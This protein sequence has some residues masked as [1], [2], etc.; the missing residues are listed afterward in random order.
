MEYGRK[1]LHFDLDVEALKR[2]YP[3]DH[4]NAWKS[5]WSKVKAFME[6]HGFEHSQY[7]GYESRGEMSYDKAYAVLFELS[8][9]Y[10]W[11]SKCAQAATV[12]EIG[13]R[14]D[15]LE[16]LRAQEKQ[17][18]QK[19]HRPQKE[20]ATQQSPSFADRAEK[21]RRASAAINDGRDGEGDRNIDR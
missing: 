14:H 15:V 9:A 12:T 7:S 20:P 13:E 4:P 16:Y 21:A 2:F 6:E 3:S 8:I 17:A 1:E 10:P 5:A 11:F 18:G 19:T